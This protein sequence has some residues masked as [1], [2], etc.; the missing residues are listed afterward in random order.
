MYKFKWVDL[1]LFFIDLKTDSAES[2]SFLM[3]YLS[4]NV[5]ASLMFATSFFGSIGAN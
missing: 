5:S 2:N 4:L 3:D 1:I